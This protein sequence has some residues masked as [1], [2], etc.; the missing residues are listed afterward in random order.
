[1]HTAPTAVPPDSRG[2][3]QVQY[4]KILFL[5]V[6]R[7]LRLNCANRVHV[8]HS[9]KATSAAGP[10]RLRKPKQT[11]RYGKSR[12]HMNAF[13]EVST[14][15]FLSGC[16]RCGAAA[17]RDS[18]GPRR[19]AEGNNDPAG[20]TDW[21]LGKKNSQR[22]SA[23]ASFF[24]W[25]EPHYNHLYLVIGKVKSDWPGINY[26]QLWFF[27]S[28]TIPTLGARDTSKWLLGTPT[29]SRS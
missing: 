13:Q 12:L 17:K 28:L 27:R 23:I 11:S 18:P 16:L 9:G 19:L 5:F 29:S 20:W 22:H 14:R 3:C 21:L 7:C 8:F 10:I 25:P 4:S 24:D 6:S 15:Q 2:S 26:R 1:M